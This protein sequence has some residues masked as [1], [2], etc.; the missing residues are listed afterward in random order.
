MS[1]FYEIR[2]CKTNS[3]QDFVANRPQGSGDLNPLTQGD[4]ADFLQE[5][6]SMTRWLHVWWLP[7]GK[8]SVAGTSAVDWMELTPDK[9]AFQAGALMSV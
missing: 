2:P 1:Q 4:L 3:L 9:K 5:T 6:A 7:N 8:R